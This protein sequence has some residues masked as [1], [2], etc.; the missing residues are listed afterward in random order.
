MADHDMRFLD[1]LGDRGRH[2]DRSPTLFHH[3]A[4]GFTRQNDGLHAAGMRIFERAQYIF[5]VARCG[6]SDDD[7][8][9]SSGCLHLAF[10]HAGKAEIVSIRGQ[11][12]RVR[13]ECNSGSSGAVKGLTEDANELRRDVL[14]VRS[15][16]AISAQEDFPPAAH[17]GRRGSL[18]EGTWMPDCNVP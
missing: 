11:K 4:A 6:N 2:A 15:A 18:F 12:A 13:G 10:K 16:A 17:Y 1:E 7:V 9:G 3:L 8:T 5:R 14:R